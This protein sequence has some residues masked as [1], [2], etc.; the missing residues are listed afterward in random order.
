MMRLL[1]QQ[2]K[3]VHVV[4]QSIVPIYTASGAG[5][6][7]S[8]VLV[9]LINYIQPNTLLIS[10]SKAIHDLSIGGPNLTIQR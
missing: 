2:I 5:Y 3:H 7:I 9:I 6:D 1:S 4:S 8:I 10:V